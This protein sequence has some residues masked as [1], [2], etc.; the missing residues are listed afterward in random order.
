MLSL[1][2]LRFHE[3]RFHSSL[4]VHKHIHC[5]HYVRHAASNVVNTVTRVNIHDVDAEKAGAIMVMFLQSERARRSLSLA[6]R[7]PQIQ[8]CCR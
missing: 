1:A 2:P 8:P 5:I 7:T 4:F 6:P 3:S